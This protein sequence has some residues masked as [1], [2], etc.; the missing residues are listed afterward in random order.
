MA[1]RLLERAVLSAVSNAEERMPEQSAAL[2]RT[3]GICLALGVAAAANWFCARRAED[4]RPPR[5]KFLSINGVRLHYVEFGS[6]P[7]VIL[8]HGNGSTLE[9]L[10]ASGLVEG[11]ADSHRVIVF[12]RPGYGYSERPRDRLWTPEAQGELIFAA[13]RDLGVYR[14]TVVGH[15]WGTLVALA[16]TLQHPAFVRGLVLISGY[17]FP[18]LR[19]DAALSAPPALPILGDILRY[20]VSPLFGRLIARRMIKKVFAPRE[21]TRRFDEAYS[22]GIALRPWQIRATAEEAAL[23]VPAA[24]R[25]RHRYGDLHVPA[26]LFAGGGDTMSNVEAQ[27]VRLHRMLPNAELHVLPNLGHMVHYFASDKITKAIQTFGFLQ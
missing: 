16:V 3:A 27:S 10:L 9:E 13:C 2:K 6:G 1:A 25:F 24:R 23:M 18:T 17:Y 4:R 26:V 20:T 7:V 14:A 21:I 19:L 15:S 5:G 22:I 12:D 8:L 11:L